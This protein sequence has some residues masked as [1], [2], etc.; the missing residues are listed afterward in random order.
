MYSPTGWSQ[1]RSE[2]W[3][4]GNVGSRTVSYLEVEPATLDHR[5]VTACSVLTV[6]LDRGE[7]VAALLFVVVCSDVGSDRHTEFGDVLAVVLTLDL[8]QCGLFG[9]E[10]S[11]GIG[12]GSRSYCGEVV[13]SAVG[14]ARV[15]ACL[16]VGVGI[17]TEFDSEAVD[18]GLDGGSMSAPIAMTTRTSSRPC[19][20]RAALPAMSSAW[21]AAPPSKSRWSSTPT[22]SAT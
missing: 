15:G 16:F 18:P 6:A 1:V 17:A 7:A 13:G 21:T 8:G 3:F 2:T 11:C 12:V 20:A 4:D 22:V 9:C 14:R 5:F 10:Q 19:T